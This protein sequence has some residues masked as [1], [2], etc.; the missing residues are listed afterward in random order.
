M[1]VDLEKQLGLAWMFGLRGPRPAPPEVVIVSIDNE[2]ARELGLEEVPSLWP[3]SLHAQL[4]RL[5]KEYG[6]RVIV[7]DV[8]FRTDRDPSSDQQLAR[9]FLNAGNVI[10]FANLNQRPVNI[11]SHYGASRTVLMDQLA[12]PTEKLAASALSYAP[13]PLPKV[14]ARVNQAWFFKASSGDIPTIPVLAFHQYAAPVFDVFR[15]QLSERIST[16]NP[17]IGIPQSSAESRNLCDLVRKIRQ[18]VQARPELLQDL[19]PHDPQVKS[20]KQIDL[21]KALYLGPDNHFID[22]YGP[23]QSIQTIPYYRIIRN[24]D[25]SEQGTEPF[26]VSG[27]AVFVGN[28]EQYQPDLRDDFNT[29]FSD[30]NGTDLSGVE[31]MATVFANLLE[32]RNI[33]PVNRFNQ[34]VILVTWGLGLGILFYLAPGFIA[35]FTAVISASL[36]LLISAALFA[37][38]GTWAPLVSPLVLQL[39]FALFSALLLRYFFTHREH[40]QFQKTALYFLPPEVIKRLPEWKQSDLIHAGRT[41]EGVCLASD[42]EGY[43]PF[44]QNME[45]EE[46]KIRLNS[47]YK[48]LFQPIEEHGG[49]ILDIVGDSMLAFWENNPCPKHTRLQACKAAIEIQRQ[50]AATRGCS[51]ETNILPTRIGLHAG[52]MIIGNV[53]AGDHFEFR[54]VG[55]MINT[56]SR[57][58][59]LNK[60][61]G[62]RIL[63]SAEVAN[64]LEDFVFR[65]VGKFQ[66]KGK[67]KHIEIFELVS[68]LENCRQDFFDL[69][70]RFLA[71]LEEYEVG[72]WREARTTFQSIIETFGADGPSQFYLRL[73][74]TYCKHGGPDTWGGIHVLEEK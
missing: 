65:R 22:F 63:V 6:A 19:V 55:D 47:Y 20:G 31:I 67:N 73:C 7:F 59:G 43:T 46:L 17:G 49:T 72:L 34:L 44:A 14:P 24:S 13:F 18:T 37:K 9:E 60:Y 39:P 62:T 45:P 52:K 53:G 68:S 66:L 15:S 27:K 57:I 25:N 23:P 50:I 10:L 61:L 70:Q 32:G 40:Q 30:E 28:S 8:F 41:V 11:P 38:D 36:Y 69:R 35:I 42:A 1:I 33:E 58:E 64:I 12:M 16:L 3:R 2:S 4:V 74:K 29:V 56:A 51:Y 26:D 21:L 5:L 71:G 54:A 48:F